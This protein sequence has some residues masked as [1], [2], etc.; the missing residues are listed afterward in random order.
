MNKQQVIKSIKAEFQNMQYAPLFEFEIPGDE[1]LFVSLKMVK[2][3][4]EFSFDNDSLPT[5]FGGDVIKT[6]GRSYL[7][8]CDE[9]T[10]SLD[11]LLQSVH[12]EMIEGYLLPNGLYV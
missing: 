1:H 5:S 3:G 12:N 4:I 9:F 11:E 7:I 8:K 6:S 10:S 2:K